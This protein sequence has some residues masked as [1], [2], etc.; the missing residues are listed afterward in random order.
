MTMK[1]SLILLLLI[2]PGIISFAQNVQYEDVVYLKNGSIIRGMI[3]EQIPNQ[4]L[5]IQTVD[6]NVFVFQFEEIE[7]ITKEEVP[8][9]AFPGY[10]SGTGGVNK[11]MIKEKGFE[12]TFEFGLG[13]LLEWGSPALGLYVIAGYRF[14]PQFV[15]SGGAGIEFY[16][17]RS[18]LPLFVNVRTDLVKARVTPFF[19]ANAGYAF[20]WVSYD[21]GSDWGGMFVEPNFGVRFNFNPNFAMNLSTG[22]KFQRAREDYYYYEP[23]YPPGAPENYT[24]TETFKIF[25]FKVGFSF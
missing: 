5:K 7:K 12:S 22:I 19:A 18:M 23:Y 10:H 8:P 17:D 20:G 25:L 1:K 4:T 11:S 14:V 21:E 6:R 16:E 24:Y 15:L 9:G 3:I 13:G 2:L